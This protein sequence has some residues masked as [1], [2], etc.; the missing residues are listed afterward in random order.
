VGEAAAAS[1]VA[2]LETLAF[3][4][5]RF[6][7]VVARRQVLHFGTGYAY[8]ERATRPAPPIPDWLEP[9]RACAEQ[10][11]GIAAS[12]F[13]ELLVTRYPP[14]AGIGWHRDAP[15]FGP[16]VVGVSLRA[17]CV[18]RFRRAAGTAWERTDVTLPARSAYVLRGR[19]RAGWQHA[20]P[21]VRETRYSITLRTLRRPPVLG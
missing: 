7:G 15:V 5:V 18:L 13:A 4:E 9:L 12:S 16:I 2:R 17:P 1:L 14:G 6:R 11:T 3:D 8:E 21:P 20:I 19:A 10:W